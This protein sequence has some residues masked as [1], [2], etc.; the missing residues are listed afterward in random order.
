MK[1]YL[2][3]C[4]VNANGP[5]QPEKIN[6]IVSWANQ[7]KCD[8]T[9]IQ[10][11]HFTKQMQ[12]TLFKE[13]GKNI[14]RSDG[15]SNSRGVAIWIKDRI[16]FK[17]IDEHKDSDGRFILINIE[18][19]ENIY[20]LVNIYAPNRSRERNSFFKT[21]KSYINKYG[22]GQTILGGDFND[23]WSL[24]DTKNKT[25][26]S[27]KI[28]K[29]VTGLKGLIKSC[30]LIDIWR[31]R[32]KNLRQFT[33]CRKDRSEATRIDYFLI[34]K[35]VQK[36]CKSCDIRPLVQK[37]TDHNAV[38]LKINTERGNK[39]RGYWKLN[40]SVLNNDDY[41][42]EIN[43]LINRYEKE[44]INCDDLGILWDNLKI[45]VRDASLDYCK[46]KA[47]LKKKIK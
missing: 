11:T 46:R 20:T 47:K 29:P 37:I 14:F 41:V 9:F 21:V 7:Q 8:I 36:N 22:L 10:E 43:K 24:I 28:D 13:L 38:S 45:E 17:I 4:T 31:S 19:N 3:I 25:K 18:I 33:W 34:S 44:S 15:T 5:Q 42:N 26:S 30:K 23:I 27:K 12:D 39:G 6:K 1:N 32:N 35:E 16:N 2:H 40:S